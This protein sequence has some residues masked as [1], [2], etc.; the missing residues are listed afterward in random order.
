[1]AALFA[2]LLPV[3]AGLYIKDYDA[4]GRV[5]TSVAGWREISMMLIGAG[6]VAVQVDGLLTDGADRLRI[7]MLVAWALFFLLGVGGVVSVWRHQNED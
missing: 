2:V 3:M 6:M 1:M 4:S 7:A 5:R